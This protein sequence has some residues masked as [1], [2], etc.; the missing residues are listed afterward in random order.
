MV[1]LVHICIH[2]YMHIHYVV[3]THVNTQRVLNGKMILVVN[4]G[5]KSILMLFRIL[6]HFLWLSGGQEA[7][8][9]TKWWPGSHLLYKDEKLSVHLSVRHAVY[10]AIS[11]CSALLFVYVITKASGIYKFVSVNF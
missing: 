1:L 3:H 7:M 8:S 10:S 9:Y 11:V 2:S 4:H 6:L 5:M